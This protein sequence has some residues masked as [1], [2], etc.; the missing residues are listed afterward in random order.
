MAN[1]S[2]GQYWPLT[3][4]VNYKYGSEEKQKFLPKNLF[5]GFFPCYSICFLLSKKF[6][7]N[8]LFFIFKTDLFS[9]SESV[10]RKEKREKKMMKI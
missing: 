8:I 5:N 3:I 7:F 6:Y 2:P 9:V 10:P 4:L 1:E